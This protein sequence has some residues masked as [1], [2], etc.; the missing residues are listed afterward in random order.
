MRDKMKALSSSRDAKALLLCVKR[1]GSMII[2]GSF[3]VLTLHKLE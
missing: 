1:S 3:V 2:Q